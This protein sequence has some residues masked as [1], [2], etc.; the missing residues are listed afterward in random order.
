MIFEH[1]TIITLNLFSGFRYDSD[2]EL[3]LFNKCN[4]PT[5]NIIIKII[6]LYCRP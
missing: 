6:L 4:F 2:V 5:D 3:K 1:I